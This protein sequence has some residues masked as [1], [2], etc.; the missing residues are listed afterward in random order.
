VREHAS[1]PVTILYSSLEKTVRAEL[2]NLLADART[3]FKRRYPEIAPTKV[4]DCRVKELAKV[5]EKLE[6][7]EKH[8]PHRCI[9]NVADS[10]K[11]EGIVNDLVAGRLVCATPNDVAKLAEIIRSWSGKRLRILQDETIY[12]GPTG[13]RAYHI[14]AEIR[15]FDESTELW[16]PV[17]I[18]LKTLL[19]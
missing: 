18:Q 8:W 12:D 7:K 11:V 19:R 6:R 3:A 17:E 16:F 15:V 5:F 13:Y 1:L 10:G 2:D 9:F 14:D 4:S